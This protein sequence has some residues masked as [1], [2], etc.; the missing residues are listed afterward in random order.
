MLYAYREVLP[1][2][3]AG[4]VPG[5]PYEK[6]LD[7]LSSISG[8]SEQT[9]LHKMIHTLSTFSEE[10][11]TICFRTNYFLFGIVSQYSIRVEES[12]DYFWPN[13]QVSNCKL[14]CLQ[15][16]NILPEAGFPSAEIIVVPASMIN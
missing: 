2:P 11:K 1:H 10:L 14:N 3:V 7:I 5:N 12:V 4:N 13:I 9:A 6:E 8:T 16:K 15:Y